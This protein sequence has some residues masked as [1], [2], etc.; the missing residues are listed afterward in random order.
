MSDS[1]AALKR[2]IKFYAAEPEI[3]A[4]ETRNCNY[5]VVSLQEGKEGR[6]EGYQGGNSREILLPAQ[7]R[8]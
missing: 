1:D 6:M 7:T 5:T 2:A 8:V 3:L 4:E